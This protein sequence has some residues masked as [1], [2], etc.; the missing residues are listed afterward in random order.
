M[1]IFPFFC[2]V[3][4]SSPTTTSNLVVGSD[5]VTIVLGK[6]GSLH[7]L[8]RLYLNIKNYLAYFEGK[9]A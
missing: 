4:D 9:T 7:N 5:H 6:K 2:L 3:T 8:V 1:F